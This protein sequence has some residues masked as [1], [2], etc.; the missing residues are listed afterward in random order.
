MLEVRFHGRGGQG[1]VIASEILATAAFMEGKYVSS[2]PYFGVERRGAPVTAFTRIDSK[3]IRVKTQIYNPDHVVVLDY[4]L[5]NAV[6]VTAG[7][8][9]EGLI[10]INTVKNP[11]DFLFDVKII[12]TVNA[13]EIALK[14]SLG[15]HSAP[16]VNT[17]ILGA[18][19][20]A[21]GVVS[22]NSIKKAIAEVVSR[23][24]DENVASA[25]EAYKSVK[26]MKK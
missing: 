25:E 15:S 8:K 20:A 21:S 11:E 13:S 4:S 19:A 10:L 9:R 1:A 12:A 26:V 17:S 16:I 3:P 14:H 2:F 5:I 18:Y 24:V 6:N 23:M 7:M 22:L